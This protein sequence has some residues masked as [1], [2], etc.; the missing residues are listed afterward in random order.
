[1]PRMAGHLPF[2]RSPMRRLDEVC[3]GQVA[4]FGASL[5]A[6][7]QDAGDGPLGLRETSS[8]FGSHF[9][10]NMK[11][12]MDVEQR[13]ILDT[14]AI[15]GRI[16]D[17]GDI[18]FARC[19]ADVDASIAALTAAICR[20]GGL[21]MMLG[22]ATKLARPMLRG[23]EAGLGRPV[24]AVPID[25][26]PHLSVDELILVTLDLSTVASS[27]H[28]ASPNSNFAGLSLREVR[29]RLR[30]LGT[31]RLAGVAV[32]GLEP[33]RAGLSTVK[34]A[35]RLLVTAVLDLLYAHLDALQPEEASNA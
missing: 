24:V 29:Q 34:T 16:V 10:S 2:L 25:L 1:M 17:L 35:Q 20:H 18:D 26:R 4:V 3:P 33:A 21:P 28:G 22:G 14:A 5:G 12:A 7:L 31:Q 13:R 30:R 11:A 23:I 32:T 19:T 8:Y 27:W 15:A 9:T 6:A